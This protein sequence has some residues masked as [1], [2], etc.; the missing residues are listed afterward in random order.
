MIMRK[1]I[2]TMIPFLAISGFLFCNGF[3]NDPAVCIE[4][5]ANATIHKIGY[6]DSNSLLSVCFVNS[7]SYC[8]PGL[9]Y[10]TNRLD[11]SLIDF[12]HIYTCENRR[13]PEPLPLPQGSQVLF[14]GEVACY[15]SCRIFIPV[16]LPGVSIEYIRRMTG[17][18]VLQL[19]T[20]GIKAGEFRIWDCN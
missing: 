2:K 16:A 3:V 9:P 1:T 7:L 11:V 6:N 14:N 5:A 8:T 13:E 4:V 19:D 12:N 20:N 10:K 17:D 18:I 15:D